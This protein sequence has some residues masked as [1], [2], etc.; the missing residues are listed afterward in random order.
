M[1]DVER[2]KKYLLLDLLI[3]SNPTG[4]NLQIRRK[5]LS[6]KGFKNRK[7]FPE[8]FVN[9]IQCFVVCSISWIPCGSKLVHGFMAG[10]TT[11]TTENKQSI[12]A[13]K[14]CVLAEISAKALP[15]PPA[16]PPG[17]CFLPNQILLFTLFID[18]FL[19]K[20]AFSLQ[21][22]LIY[23]SKKFNTAPWMH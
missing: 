16:P 20:N 2:G 22:R 11:A 21:N 19:N 17:W 3:T 5:K 4:T 1:S 15:T 14:N 18:V 12:H 8:K 23:L 10:R 6:Q 9:F 13:L 7:S